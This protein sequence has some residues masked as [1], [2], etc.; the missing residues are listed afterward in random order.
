MRNRGKRWRVR[1]QEVFRQIELCGKPVIACVNGLA[2]GGGCELALACTL[3][4]ASENAKMG[5]PEVKLGLIPGYGGTQRLMRLVGRGAAL[6]M[7]LTAEVVGAA[8]GSAAGLVEEV[9]PAAELMARANE[10]AAVIAAMAPLA[11]E[12]VLEAVEHGS[13]L[14]EWAGRWRL[15]SLGGCAGRTI[16]ARG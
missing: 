9:V 15:R 16:S 8:G 12:G 1:G 10:L 11:V 7:M 5:L 3:R 6:K 13:D 4:I 2:L 14:E